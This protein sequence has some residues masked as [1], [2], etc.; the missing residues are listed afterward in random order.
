[1]FYAVES[2]CL[3]SLNILKILTPEIS[4]KYFKHIFKCVVHLLKNTGLFVS[5]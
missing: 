3:K 1:M 4:I 5:P 2:L